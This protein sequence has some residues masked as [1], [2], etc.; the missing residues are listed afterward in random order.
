MDYYKL[1]CGVELPQVLNEGKLYEYFKL[2]EEGS[3]E[4]RTIVI[5]TNIKLVLYLVTKQF[6][7]TDY[8]K[9][10]LIS[11]GLIG[12][13][14]AVDTFDVNRGVKFVTYAAKCIINEIFS[15]IKEDKRY[16]DSLKDNGCLIYHNLIN[17]KSDPVL[18][19]ESYECYKAMM[20]IIEK[21][22]ERDKKVIMCYYGFMDIKPMTQKEI[23]EKF[24]LSQSNIFKIISR[25][26]K[27]IKNELI[28]K[29]LVEETKKERVGSI[30]H[31]NKSKN[32]K[33]IYEYFNDYSK[34]Q[35]NLMLS[36]LTDEEKELIR[37]RYGDD[38][39]N[40]ITSENW[41]EEYS[42][43]FYGRLVKKMKRLLL[44]YNGNKKVKIMKSN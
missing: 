3:K 36:K 41:T 22:P 23:G 35:V 29:E 26:L 37:L 2:I 5:N 7:E 16:Y 21:M 17:E 4:A 11:I 15:F 38:L 19:N 13:I 24:G 42:Q 8:D 30:K 44:N 31:K 25:S 32:L 18:N 33:T 40:P 39:D 9:E 43:K 34:E 6:C 28:R 20:Q 1:L 27:E 12:L 10:E 14:K